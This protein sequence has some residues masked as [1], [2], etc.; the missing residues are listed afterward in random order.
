M[1]VTVQ[2]ES[3]PAREYTDF[4]SP[5]LTSYN[6]EFDLVSSSNLNFKV[7]FIYHLRFVV[8]FALRQNS[9]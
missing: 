7:F 4:S 8:H 6:E 5:E 2:P 1:D 3:S 9:S